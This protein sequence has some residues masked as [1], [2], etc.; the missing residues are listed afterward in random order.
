M[1]KRNFTK[2]VG[3]ILSEETYNQLIEKTNKE[4][5]SV[6]AWIRAAVENGLNQG[7]NPSGKPAKHFDNSLTLRGKE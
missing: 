3:L 2:Q 4:E 5:M 1:R 6:S 7:K